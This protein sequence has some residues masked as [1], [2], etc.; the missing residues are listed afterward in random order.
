[1]TDESFD[2][3]FVGDHQE[4]LGSGVMKGPGDKFNEDVFDPQDPTNKRLLDE[5]KVRVI[6][7]PRPKPTVGAEE[8]AATDSRIDL[9]LVE[10]TGEGGRVTKEDVE[11]AIKDLPPI[12]EDD[13][14]EEGG[15]G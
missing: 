2:F 12:E 11:K 5:D 3:I 15:E 8:L 6:R 4:E 7:K 14:S 1:M 13:N 9:A 10:G